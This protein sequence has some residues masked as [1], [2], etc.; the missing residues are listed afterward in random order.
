MNIKKA[1]NGMNLEPHSFNPNIHVDYEM[2]FKKDVIK[3]GTILKFKG[4]RGTFRFRCLA[5][6][7]KTGTSWVDCYDESAGTLR[8][9]SVDKLQGVVKKRSRRHKE[10]E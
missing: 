2:N 10:N 9:F 8:A 3:P 7:S 6:N 5:H 1:V 4:T